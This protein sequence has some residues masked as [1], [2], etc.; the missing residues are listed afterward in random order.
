M[1]NTSDV[2]RTFGNVNLDYAPASWLRLSYVL[3]ADY[4]LDNRRTVLPKT[5]SDNILGRMIR[6]DIETFQ[7]ESRLVA[8]LNHNFSENAV[9]TLSL[10]QNLNQDKFSQ[11]QV[12][13]INLVYGAD[14][15]DFAVDKV[16]T[17]FRSTTRG[18]GYFA[19]GEMTL[20]DQLTLN[21]NVL[22][23]GS[24]TFGGVGKRFWYPGIGM[25]WQVSKLNAFE[26]MS[27]L[28][29]LKLRASYGVS[30][31]QPPV[32]S[33]QGGYNIANIID[34]WVNVGNQTIF[35]GND[36]LLTDPTQG[37]PDIRPE[38]KKEWEAGFDLAVLGGRAA[39]GFTYYNRITSDM[40]L[41]VPL[42]SSSG[43]STQFQNAA[44]VDNHGIEL[45]LDL[46]PV[47]KDNFGWQISTTY[48][49]NRSCVK[50]LGGTEQITL[51]GFEGSVTAVVA[52]DPVT[53]ACYPF[54][55]FYGYD[56]IRTGRGS[57]DQNTG[58]DIDAAF[59][60]A[61]VGAIYIGADGFPQLDPQQRAFGNPN[62]DWTGSFRNT[63]TIYG[64]LRLSGLL[65]VSQGG[66]MWNGTKGALYSFGTHAGTL[67]FQGEGIVAAFGGSAYSDWT[68]AGPGAGM[69]VPLNWYTWAEEG[70]GNGF[71]GPFTQFVEDAS[72]V[73]LRDVSLSYTFDSPS[74]RHRFGLSSLNLTV[75]GRN[76]KTWT[77]Y[78]GIDPE[79]NLTGQS[80]GRGLDYFNNPQTR[81][82]VIS[83]SLNR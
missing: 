66:Q 14:Q 54:G 25:S 24:S 29:Q 38:K 49:R 73:K 60:S 53:G 27:W 6:A 40:I 62:P 51:A 42:P 11:Y 20:Y 81:S 37:N 67:P 12:N 74:L 21:A 3:G 28:D 23:E 72:F 13:G 56:W 36:G 63:F 52:P 45:T 48:A 75:S 71:N 76:L 70:L 59:P 22:N 30:G 4:S 57:L 43:Y 61:P 77:D 58:D 46:N 64:N 7:I 68:V 34:G 78:T 26:N 5:S 18:D 35:A 17:E 10:G 19:N 32:F 33:N 69:E 9:G 31:R 79:S 65:D 47:Q 39:L 1:P 82:W 55:A 2:D 83:V 44:R 8:T 41:G 16:P 50:D 80:V 15:L